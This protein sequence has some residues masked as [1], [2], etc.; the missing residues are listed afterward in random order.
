MKD[1]FEDLFKP[2]W[3]KVTNIVG[4]IEKINLEQF[5]GICC[6]C[7]RIVSL[8]HQLGMFNVC[9]VFR[10]KYV[11][12]YGSRLRLAVRSARSLNFGPSRLQ[13]MFKMEFVQMHRVKKIF[14]DFCFL[15]F[16][17]STISNSAFKISI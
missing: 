17:I 4:D 6:Y 13:A 2:L 15:R 14:I 8:H 11:L 9:I 12:Q 1:I 5:I 7:Y 3:A 10:Q 16:A